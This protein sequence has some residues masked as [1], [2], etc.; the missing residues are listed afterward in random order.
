MWSGTAASSGP[1]TTCSGFDKPADSAYIVGT[2]LLIATPTLILYGWLSDK[3]GRKPVILGG[4]FLAS[5]SPTIPCI[6]GWERS[7]SRVR[8]TSGLRSAS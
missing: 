7:R 1:S 8:S 6:A 2:A 5:R 4:M 3:I